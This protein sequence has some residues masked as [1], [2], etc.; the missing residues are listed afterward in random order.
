VLT[1]ADFRGGALLGG[2]G[3]DTARDASDLSE[4]VLDFALLAR[5]RMIGADLHDASLVGAN[6]EGTILQGANLTGADLAGANLSGAVLSRAQA[7][8]SDA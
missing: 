7:S 1:E 8:A 3:I 2:N 5:A 4:C 6:L